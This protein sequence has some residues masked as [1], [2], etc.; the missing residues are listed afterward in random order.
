MS[1]NASG[2]SRVGHYMLSTHLVRHNETFGSI[3]TPR[4]ISAP[5][6]SGVIAGAAL[7]VVCCG[8]MVAC[9]SN[10]AQR[11]RM[12]PAYEGLP[13]ITVKSMRR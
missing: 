11:H 2:L 5:L 13:L 12:Q 10:C 8:L 9:R 7:V 6:W 4:D 3:G 1:V